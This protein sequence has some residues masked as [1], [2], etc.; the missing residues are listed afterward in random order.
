MVTSAAGPLGAEGE[1]EDEPQAYENV[2]AAIAA[3][4]AKVFRVMPGRLASVVPRGSTPISRGSRPPAETNDVSLYSIRTM[5]PGAHGGARRAT[6]R[7]A[8][9]SAPFRP[10]SSAARS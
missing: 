6:D 3:R 9:V 10:S 1:E 2:A 5:R 8:R 4:N 7:A